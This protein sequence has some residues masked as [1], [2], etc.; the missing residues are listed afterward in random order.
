MNKNS[1]KCWLCEKPAVAARPYHVGSQYDMGANF[2]TTEPTRH[3]R[4]YC[5]ECYDKEY[6][7]VTEEN[8]LYRI[9][10][11]KKMFE[12]A[13]K[14]LEDQSILLWKYR[15]AINTVEQYNLEKVDKFDSSYEIIAAIILIQNEIKTNIHYKIDD[16]EVDFLLP[17]IC[18][19]LEIDGDRHKYQKEKDS[20]R[21]YVLK[22]KLGEDWEV[23]RIK[24]SYLDKHADRLVSAI[25]KTLDARDKAVYNS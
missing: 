10:R 9:L 24:T 7:R 25:T 5:Q 12:S 13:I 17:D 15:E 18:V 1:I 3:R 20:V 21:D 6:E 4:C 8:R 19:V 11:K 14:T 16:Y 23:I 2:V 22:K